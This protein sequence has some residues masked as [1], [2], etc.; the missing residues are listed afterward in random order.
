MDKMNAFELDHL[1]ICCKAGAPEAEYLRDFGLTEGPPNVHP[2]QGTMN[3]RFYFHN[4]MLEL[5]W[6]H[7]PVGAQNMRTRPTHLWERWQGRHGDASPFGICLHPRHAETA[8]LLGHMS[9]PI[10][11]PHW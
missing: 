4:A 10:C 7:D 6:V 9:Q 3:R 5:L 11:R 8:T 2:G 1:F